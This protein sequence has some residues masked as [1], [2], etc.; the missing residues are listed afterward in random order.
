MSQLSSLIITLHI[1]SSSIK[2]LEAHR[3]LD[4]MAIRRTTDHNI[5]TPSMEILSL[6]NLQKIVGSK[7]L[8]VFVSCI[9]FFS[10]ITFVFVNE[11]KDS[12]IQHCIF[13][14]QLFLDNQWYRKVIIY[15]ER[16]VK[17]EENITI[18]KNWKNQIWQPTTWKSLKDQKDHID[19]K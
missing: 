12:E 7:A 16:H 17:S 18:K 4:N 19:L 11:L 9:F 1:E 3:F 15:N 5:W 8:T 6:L 10:L 13:L 14:T 2:G